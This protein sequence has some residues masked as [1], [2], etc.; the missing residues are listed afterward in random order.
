M[1]VHSGVPY[2]ASFSHDGK[3]LTTNEHITV[4]ELQ[5][6]TDNRQKA[7][8]NLTVHN[9]VEARDK[10]DYKCTIMDFYNNTNSVIATMTFVTEPVIELI[11]ANPV[12]SVERGK[13]QAQFLIDYTAFPSATFYLFNPKNEQ[14]SS[15]QDVMDRKKYDV[16]ITPERF[17]FKVKYPDLTDFGNYTIVATTVGRN[18]TTTVKLIVSGKIKVVCIKP[19]T[20]LTPFHSIRQTHREHGRRVRHGWRRSSHGL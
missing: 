20:V 10:G 4:S 14:V 2:T 16:E 12:I 17:K 7:H 18:F 8:L 19:F 9:S 6:E 13:K 15:D 11:P 5:H 3:V 1:E